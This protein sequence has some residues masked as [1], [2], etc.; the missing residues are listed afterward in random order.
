MALTAE[1]LI[2][3]WVRGSHTGDDGSPLPY[4]SA[5]PYCPPVWPGEERPAPIN[6]ELYR[7]VESWYQRRARQDQLVLMYEYLRRSEY[8]GYR[9]RERYRKIAWQLKISLNDFERSLDR[10]KANLQEYYETR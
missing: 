4:K 2:W 7:F 3:N 5:L 8:R 9:R 10:L 6:W 1:D